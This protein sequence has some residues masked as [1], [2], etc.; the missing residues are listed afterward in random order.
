MDQKLKQNI[1]LLIK[2]GKGF[3]KVS[4][5]IL[6]SLDRNR[7]FTH[8]KHYIIFYNQIL[9]ITK[10]QHTK[11]DISSLGELHFEDYSL[12]PAFH[13]VV[14]LLLPLSFT[15]FLFQWTYIREIK[16]KIREGVKAFEH[17]QV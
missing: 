16:N 14:I 11:E 10:R 3:E 6:F 8:L 17:I 12:R 13:F 7:F 9:Q 2:D 5:L 15:I 4:I 1:E